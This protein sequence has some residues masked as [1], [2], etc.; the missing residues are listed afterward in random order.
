[1][2]KEKEVKEETKEVKSNEP[3]VTA[4]DI[5]EGGKDCLEIVKGIFTKPFDVIKKFAVEKKFLTGVIMIVITAI[6]NGLCKIATLKNMYGASSSDGFST[7]E[8]LSA[9]SGNYSGE[10][11]YLE[12]FFKAFGYGLLEYAAIAVIGYLLI[13]KVL[14]GK[15]TLK[16]VVAMAGVSLT[17]VALAFLVNAG[18]V[19]I[20]SEFVSYIRSYITTLG[21]IFSVAIFYVCI[22]ELAGIDKNKLFLTVAGAFIAGTAAVDLVQKILE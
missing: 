19:Y 6:A 17:V 4:D 3:A 16:Q 1:M 2:E 22:S 18:L 11:D 7:A 14:K 10:P 5:K 21:Y 9:M 20:D 8:I 12:E 15:A 13:T